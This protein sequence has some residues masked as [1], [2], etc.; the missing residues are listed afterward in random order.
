MQKYLVGA[1]KPTLIKKTKHQQSVGGKAPVVCGEGSKTL[2]GRQL[3]CLIATL[4]I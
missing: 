3:K 4:E 2:D 1:Q